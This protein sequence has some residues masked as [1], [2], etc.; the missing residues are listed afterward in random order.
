MHTAYI[1]VTETDGLIM[2]LT[3][4]MRQNLTYSSENPS[5]PENRPILGGR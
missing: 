4:E 1:I 3:L 5:N 2:Q